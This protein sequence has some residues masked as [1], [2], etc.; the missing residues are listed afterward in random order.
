MP[1][2]AAFNAA[3]K[4][5]DKLIDQFAADTQCAMQLQRLRREIQDL[6]TEQATLQQTLNAL[7][8]CDL[9]R[10]A[11]W[12]ALLTAS[13][14]PALTPAALQ[15]WQ[16]LLP[17]AHQTAQTLQ[18]KQDQLEH[19]RQI[20]NA[21]TDRLQKAVHAMGIMAVA[22]SA[23]LQ[24][25]IAA[26]EQIQAQLNQ[27]D[28]LALQA[29]GRHAELER[30]REELTRSELGAIDSSDAAASARDA[31]ERAAATVHS[32]MPHWIRTR[33]AQ[34]LLAQALKSF[35]KRAQGPMLKSASGY[36]ARMTG[37]EFT[38]LV[39]NDSDE[40]VLLAERHNGA[41]LR[42]DALSEGTRDQLYLALRLA[43]LDLQRHAGVDLPAVFDDILMTSDEHRAKEILE[44]LADFR[45]KIRSFC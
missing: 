29:S 21:L 28:A 40:P 16:R 9:Q 42:V 18:A 3:L 22:P 15:D 30:Q 7:E 17:I 20:E 39:N 26:A 11:S 5:A 8:Q 35:R 14:L 13:N 45:V 32:T 43:A 36:F 27:H 33:L 10:Q 41:L 23:G 38:R 1:L 19:A 25:L 4:Q 2:P 34:A 37:Q 12:D 24:T 31:M 44:A 6:E